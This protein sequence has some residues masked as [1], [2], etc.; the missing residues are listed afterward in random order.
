MAKKEK[1]P[2]VPPVAAAQET[3]PASERPSASHSIYADWERGIIVVTIVVI[4]LTCLYVGVR[5]E[6]IASGWQF[7][8][9]RALMSAAVAMLT[10]SIAG[11]LRVFIGSGKLFAIRATGSSAVLVLLY[12]F[13][14]PEL[15]NRIFRS[16][17]IV[18]REPTPIPIPIKREESD[19]DGGVPSDTTLSRHPPNDAYKPDASRGPAQHDAA[20]S[21]AQVEMTE[22]PDA[23]VQSSQMPVK[24]MIVATPPEAIIVVHNPGAAIRST[25]PLKAMLVPGSYTVTADVSPRFKSKSQTI[26][27]SSASEQ[28]FEI[29]LEERCLTTCVGSGSADA[30]DLPESR[31]YKIE[32]VDYGMADASALALVSGSSTVLDVTAENKSVNLNGMAHIRLCAKSKDGSVLCTSRCMQEFD[33]EVLSVEYARVRLR[34]SCL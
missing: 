5:A 17:V 14:P 16:N 9:L 15:E 8:M 32:V 29:R 2:S 1:R 28:T 4:V 34:I 11:G 23:I 12:M 26:V 33:E 24:V 6:P 19:L 30:V 18:E 27:V 22:L 3:E 21:D 7:Y 31:K 10:Y 25:S 13:N 20:V